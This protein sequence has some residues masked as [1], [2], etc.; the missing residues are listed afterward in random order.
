MAQQMLYSDMVT[1]KENIFVPKGLAFHFFVKL[2]LIYVFN[3]H[4]RK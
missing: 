3:P 2:I 1:C 4:C